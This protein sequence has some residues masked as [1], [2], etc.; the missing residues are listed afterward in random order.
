M[1]LLKPALVDI[2]PGQPNVLCN[3]E[4]VHRPARLEYPFRRVHPI[5][6]WL[7]SK[8]ATW[9]GENFGQELCIPRKI[10]LEWTV[11]ELN[12]NLENNL[13]FTHN[14]RGQLRTFCCIQWECELYSGRPKVR[15][16]PLNL[17]GHSFRGKYSQVF[18]IHD[19]Q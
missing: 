2:L 14:G 15:C 19:I 12:A 18:H 7:Q 9:I 1:H 13:V 11:G 3:D 16:Y 5:L 8:L 17:S 6:R 4:D 10:G